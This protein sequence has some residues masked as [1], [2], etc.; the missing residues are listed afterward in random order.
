[1]LSHDSWEL[2]SRPGWNCQVVS[3][4]FNLY[5]CNQTTMFSFHNMKVAVLFMKVAIVFISTW[6]LVLL[7]TI[8][9]TGW[10]WLFY[11]G[12]F[13]QC[14]F[15]DMNTTA[16]D[17]LLLFEFANEFCLNW[18]HQLFRINYLGGN[19]LLVLLNWIHQWILFDI[20]FKFI[21]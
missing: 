16:I 9:L 18:I 4:I 14:L 11:L 10:S 7:L 1:M 2:Q 19:E 5:A 8:Y 21:W 6:K 15:L 13:G 3:I 20:N 17:D 12:A